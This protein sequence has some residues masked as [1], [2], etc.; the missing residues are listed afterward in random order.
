MRWFVSRNGDTQ[1]PF[2][3]SQIV[4][5][6]QTRAIGTETYVRDEHSP[7]WA[8]ISHS[9]FAAH[10]NPPGPSKSGTPSW[11]KWA[12][13]SLAALV[14]L[15]ICTADPKPSSAPA[16]KPEPVAAV[17]NLEEVVDTV[18]L[19]IGVGDDRNTTHPFWPADNSSELMLTAGT[20]VERL[21]E[22]DP[23]WRPKR[24]PT[25]ETTPS[26]LVRA[27]LVGPEHRGTI[28]YVRAEHV[29]AARSASGLPPAVAKLAAPEAA[30]KP[31]AT[32]QEPVV[33]VRKLQPAPKAQ[34]LPSAKPQ[35][36]PRPATQPRPKPSPRVA[37]P[38]LCRDG[39][40]SPTCVCGGSKRGCCSHHG[41][42][43]GCSR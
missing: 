3:E 31:T 11:L 32:A 34:P 20:R 12:G 2:E 1:G 5:W 10:L 37:A 39:T 23:S 4:Y 29:Q 18:A 24:A 9:P 7:H 8:P 35:P 13:G 42:V 21:K 40:L 16:V 28:G 22:R 15:A 26:C 27:R 19:E 41:G 6:L 33:A 36:K 14:G 38:L 30:A 25:C 43:A 17:V